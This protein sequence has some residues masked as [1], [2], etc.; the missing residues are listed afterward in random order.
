MAKNKVS[1]FVFFVATLLVTVSVVGSAQPSESNSKVIFVD[2]RTM[3]LAHPLFHKF[4]VTTRRFA[5][6]RSEPVQGESGRKMIAAELKSYKRA[7]H[8]F[9]KNWAD[10]LSRASGNMRVRLEKQYLSNK[11][12]FEKKI[13]EVR[14]RYWATA[15][16]PSVPG[17]TE[18][19]SIV[20]QVNQISKDIRDS[21][22][23]LKNKTGADMVIDISSLMPDQEI[24]YKIEL[25]QANYLSHFK[26][27]TLKTSEI[28]DWVIEAR[29]YWLKHGKIYSPV[30]SGALDKRVE[31]V[32]LLIRHCRG[33]ER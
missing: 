11:A 4:D 17:L 22:V 6:T 16:I 1:V 32:E 9:E 18:P 25:V 21:L 15:T 13:S 8:K 3:L 2:T 26:A 14:Q 33:L 24:T 23:K 28:I 7:F 29:E 10:K 12:R 27:G 20:T 31:A 5:G 19:A 30:I